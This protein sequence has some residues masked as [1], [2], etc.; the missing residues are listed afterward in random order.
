[1]YPADEAGLD[2][3]RDGSALSAQGRKLD[4]SFWPIRASATIN[5]PSTRLFSLDP[6]AIIR[7]SIESECEPARLPEALA[8]LGQASA[9]F[10]VGTS[11]GNEAARPLALYYSYLNLMKAYCLTRGGVATFERSLHGLWEEHAA[12]HGVENAVLSTV[13]PGRPFAT[14]LKVFERI[15]MTLPGQ[16]PALAGKYRLASVV[17]QILSGHR[18]WAEA[19]DET[20]RFFIVRD[21]A[22][23]HHPA[24]GDVWLRIDMLREDLS[25]FGIEPQDMLS[26]AGLAGT[27][28]QVRCDRPKRVRFEQITPRRPVDGDP[29][30][31]LQHLIDALRPSLW[32]TVTVIPPYRRYYLYLSPSTEADQ[33][34]P[35]L[36]SMY[37]MTYW[38]GSITRYRPHHFDELL[39]GNYGPR[40][41]DFVT[42]QPL[43]FLYLMA[44]EISRRDVARPSI[45]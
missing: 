30:P 22:F 28:R 41:R 31:E 34:L 38:L 10:E 25:R 21:I 32:M 20:E 19:A 14:D 24:S 8:C 23:R 3:E 35:Q 43:Q 13:K 16:S 40:I 11:Q 29:L 17:P 37:A 5:V 1:M 36:L 7:Q 4:F 15:A 26:R 45:L 27:F 9:F 33:R 12:G 2:G 6:W 39:R 18:L 42:G 44:S